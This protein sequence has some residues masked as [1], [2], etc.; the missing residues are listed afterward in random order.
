METRCPQCK[1]PVQPGATF[2]DNCGCTLDPALAGAASGSGLIAC[3]MCGTPNVPGAAYCDSCGA[4]LPPITPIPPAQDITPSPTPSAGPLPAPTP[5]PTPAPTPIP[6]PVPPSALSGFLVV[7][8][9]GVRIELPQKAEALLGREDPVSNNFP[10]IDLTPHDGLNQGVSR[11]HARI[12]LENGQ[13]M[14]E[15][16]NAVN[17]T[18]LNGQRLDAGKQVPIHDGDVIV[19]GKLKLVYKKA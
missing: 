5:E 7:E 15:D 16:L 19:L 2:C 12:L 13:M 6:I 17:H 10:E 14:L 9:S 1:A 8:A 4:D 11:K 18:Y 3:P